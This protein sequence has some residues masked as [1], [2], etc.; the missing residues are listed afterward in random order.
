MARKK[1]G[2]NKQSPKKKIK[3]GKSPKKKIET[4]EK[5]NE[6][7]RQERLLAVKQA[8][9]AIFE[10]KV[11]LS[12]S[13][14]PDTKVYLGNLPYNV[15]DIEITEFF[16]DCGELLKLHRILGRKNKFEGQVIIRF[17]T[18]EIS[19][20]AVL[21]NGE[22]FS[23]RVLVCGYPKPNYIKPK[24]KKSL[25]KPDGCES[26]FIANLSEDVD[27]GKIKHLLKDC[28]VIYKIQIVPQ[29]K[30][31]L[32]AWI[33][34]AD[35]D[36]ALPIAMKYDGTDFL[37]RKIRVDYNKPRAKP[38]GCNTVFVGDIPEDKD[39]DD[40]KIKELFKDCGAIQNISWMAP[41]KQKRSIFVRFADPDLALPIAIKL[42]NHNFHGNILTV[43]YAKPTRPKPTKS[44]NNKRKYDK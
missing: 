43:G 20:R 11:K 8:R 27:K 30:G 42:N 10:A 36:L 3:T 26:I 13:Y 31:K 4:V 39:I 32:A 1:K 37:G 7:L 23:G 28:G 44:Q 34:F 12:Q 16:K 5:T 18:L 33:R 29:K 41:K 40:D 22:E 38:D 21:K 35:P 17:A 9:A 24:K 19:A 25:K 15:S 6:D 14:P 2:G